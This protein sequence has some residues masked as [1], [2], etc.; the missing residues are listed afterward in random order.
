[1]TMDVADFLSDFDQYDQEKLVAEMEVLKK[2]ENG[3]ELNAQT[4]LR[5]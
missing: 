2:W 5:V 1:L 4:L 3:L